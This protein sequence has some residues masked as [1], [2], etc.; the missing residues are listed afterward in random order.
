MSDTQ[1]TTSRGDEATTSDPPTTSSRR[2]EANARNA[3]LST[4]PRSPQGKMRSRLNALKHGM[5][6]KTDVLPGE[7]AAAFDARLRRW[8]ADLA[9]RDDVEAFLVRRAVQLSW[10]LP[11]ANGSPAR[12]ASRATRSTPS[13]VVERRGVPVARQSVEDGDRPDG[14]PGMVAS[15][16]VQASRPRPSPEGRTGLAVRRPRHNRSRR[17]LL[18][19][20]RS[21]PACSARTDP[22][23]ALSRPNRKE[24]S[25]KSV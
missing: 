4:G 19:S 1:T 18:L 5:R 3:Q 16:R 6:A 10:Q 9:P 12:P 23:G 17:A 14:G 21:S 20:S 7:D 24:I 11:A 13:I 25:K 15:G 22:H 8:T 2:A